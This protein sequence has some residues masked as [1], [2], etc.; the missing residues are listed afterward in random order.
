MSSFESLLQRDGQLVYRVKGVSMEPMLR[1]D[2][3]L[4][5]LA[6][7]SAPLKRYDVALYRRGGDYVLH[8]VIGVEDGGYLII[9]D[10]AYVPEHVARESVVA[11]LTGFVR[12]GRRYSADDA[13]YL[14]YVR[15]WCAVYP[16]RA[17]LM[18]VRRRIGGCVRRLGLRKGR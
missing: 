3:D 7:P 5:V 15:V 16:V 11:V 2:R 1:Q 8:R 9:G 18:A 12:N 4:V 6:P 10:N 17:F 13:G 14:R